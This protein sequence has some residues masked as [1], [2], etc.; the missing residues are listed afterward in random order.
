MVLETEGFYQVSATDCYVTLWL[1]TSSKEE[2]KTKTILN[3]SE[4]EWNETFCFRIQAQV[5]NIL[6]LRVYDEDPLTRDDLL[7]TVLFDVAEVRLRERASSSFILNSEIANF[8]ENEIDEN[9]NPCSNADYELE[10]DYKRSSVFDTS[11]LHMSFSNNKNFK[12]NTELEVEFRMDEIYRLVLQLS[13]VTGLDLRSTV[14]GSMDAFPTCLLFVKIVRA[15]NMVKADLLSA[16]DC[17][18]T[19]WLPTSSKEEAKTKTILNS[20]EP[21]WNE[22]FCFRIQAQVKNILELRVYDEDPLTRD[23]LLFTVLF[24]VA[25]VRLRER[26]SSSFILNSE[27]A[28]FPENEID[29]NLNPCSNAD[30]ELEIDYKRSSVFD[31][32]MLHMSFS[33]NKNFKSNTELEVEFRMDEILDPPE[34]LITNGILV[35]RPLSCLEVSVSKERSP[36]CL[37]GEDKLELRV[38]GSY[39]ETQKTVLDSGLVESFFFHYPAY[40]EPELNAHLQHWSGDDG[41]DG[42]NSTASLTMP[43]K[44]LRMGQEVKVILPI[45]HENLDMR[46][47]FDLCSQEKDFLQK[48]KKVVAAA[49]KE[50]LHLEENLQDHEVPVVAIMATGGGARAMTS[51]YGQLSGL[52]KLNLL[53]CITYIGG[54]SGSTWTMSSL[55]EDAS[56]SQKDLE[57]PINE[58]QKH[59]T[60]SKTNTFSL[61][62]VVHYQRQLSQRAK[63]GFSISFNDLWAV[64]LEY[65]LHGK[66]NDFKLSD[67]QQAVSQGQNPLPLYLAL[68]VKENHM[69]TANFKEWCEFSPFEVG[70]PK[71]GAFIRS[72]DF[73]SEFFMGQLMK[74]NPESRICY[75]EGLWSNIF[76]VNLLDIWN[77]FGS[78]DKFW[79]QHVQAKIK[80]IEEKHALSKSSSYLGTSWINPAGMLSKIIKDILTD[81]PL[82]HHVHNFLRGLQLHKDYYQQSPFSIWKDSQ[83]DVFPNQLTPSEDD[84][85]LVDAAYFINTSCPPLLRKER[86]VNIILSF[87][88][89][90]N[91]AFEVIDQTG[92]YCSEQG[93]PFPKIVLSEEEKKHPKE[94]YVFMDEENLKT[95]IVLHFPLVNNT[96]RKFKV[97][98]VE[99]SPAE[100]AEGTVPLAGCCSP[101]N[102]LNMTYC[103]EDFDKLLKLTDYNVQNNRDLILQAFRES[104][105]R[106]KCCSN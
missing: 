44:L 43:L 26:A 41:G 76:A 16:T 58:A 3:S 37:E 77:A 27:I 104:I 91:T 29:E 88:Y 57:R 101:Y 98:G 13:F 14:S 17:Y 12:S 83:L 52:K 24:D 4:P 86:N 80:N 66:V 79:Q 67:Q 23:D 72:E 85:C 65:I 92:Q 36:K 53:D 102:L 62:H 31:T 54:T 68:N 56:W 74:K 22:T 90:L 82:H 51:L 94:C 34:N 96:F 78:S 60:K 71:Y 10:I 18:V 19:L 35:S 93:I 97:P 2:A 61:E 20:S 15:R 99:R 7:F 73:G 84:L 81:R 46:L 8:P 89:S 48:R 59:V 25:E 100:L 39:E 5:K 11:M 42:N 45:V 50:I 40:W 6:E 106:K 32:S 87:D 1:P 9:L 105:S 33:N 75:L 64:A 47:G 38:K 70:F 95:P 103:K 30:Y 55:Y 69:S 28:N 63:E 21:E 49:L